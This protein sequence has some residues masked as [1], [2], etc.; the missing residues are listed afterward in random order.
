MGKIRRYRTAW[1]RHHRSRGFG[2]HSPFAF[3][4]V[5]GVLRERLP[6]YSYEQIGQLRKNV[7]KCTGS[8][9]RN[10]EG[11][12]SFKDAKMLFRIVNYFNPQVMLQVGITHGVSSASMLAVSSTSRL[13][14]HAPNLG[15]LP[16]ASKIISRY[17]DAVTVHN[18]MGE[19]LDAYR[20]NLG[21]NQ[22][23]VLVDDLR[24]QDDC[25]RLLAYLADAMKGP[26][27]IVMRHITRNPLIKQLW[28]ACKQQAQ[29]G[30]TYTNEKTSI[31]IT[32]P[33]LQREDFFLWL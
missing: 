27:V 9:W 10:R 28:T 7:L 29:H 3:K 12:M 21:E 20:E 11:V 14:L 8:R 4:F 31:I 5:R 18:G 26:A 6:Y 23:F 1:S 2:I 30:Q 33:K 16:I 22:P 19:T 15:E 25:D 17:G 24:T 32:T 13:H